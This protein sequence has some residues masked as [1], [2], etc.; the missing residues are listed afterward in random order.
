M[1]GMSWLG[2]HPFSSPLSLRL[3]SRSWSICCCCLMSCSP[4]FFSNDSTS[5]SADASRIVAFLGVPE[6]HQPTNR[7]ISHIEVAE[8][9]STRW[10]ADAAH[11]AALHLVP[12]QPDAPLASPPDMHVGRVDSADAVVHLDQLQG[13]PQE[14]F[15]LPLLVAEELC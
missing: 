5:L 4:C 13:E 11:A 3:S 6:P 7:S 1:P 2:P 9:P 15:F 12:L 10:S 14:V 8:V